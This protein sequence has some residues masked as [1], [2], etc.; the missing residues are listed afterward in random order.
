M[1][2]TSHVAGESEGFGGSVV[3]ADLAGEAA[4][5]LEA[6]LGSSFVDSSFGEGLFWRIHVFL[7]HG[8]IRT[9]RGRTVR[10]YEPR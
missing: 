5:S 4:Y 9:V 1:G 6:R 3:V 8:S 2:R 7:R 10:R